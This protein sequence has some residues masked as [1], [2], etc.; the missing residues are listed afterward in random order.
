[1][2]SLPFSR[3]I[4]NRMAPFRRVPTVHADACDARGRRPGF[5]VVYP[6]WMRA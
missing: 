4:L 1:M 6:P 5:A 2:L 3:D